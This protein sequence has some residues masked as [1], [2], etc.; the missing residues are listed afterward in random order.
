VQTRRFEDDVAYAGWALDL[1][2]PG[3][4]YGKQRPT[5]FH[6]FPEIHSIPL[7]CLY[8]KDLK[9]LWMAGRNVSA[10]HVA[11]GGL[12]LMASCGLMGE[13]VGV[14]AAVSHQTNLFDCRA[15]ARNQRQIAAVA[16]RRCC[17]GDE[18]GMLSF[19]KLI[20]AHWGHGNSKLASGRG[21][22]QLRSI[23][24]EC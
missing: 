4:F 1:H 6:F 10:T 19:R 2:P 14:A 24:T 23:F 5:T 15:T 7:R 21:I 11:L 17:S 9:N 16:H 20:A 22:A 18:T 3:G 12:R 8:S 13:A